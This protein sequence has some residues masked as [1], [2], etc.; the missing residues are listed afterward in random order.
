MSEPRTSSAKARGGR[1][2]QTTLRGCILCGG[3][4]TVDCVDNFG[5]PYKGCPNCKLVD[6]TKNNGHERE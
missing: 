3:Q 1:R 5:K 2:Y 6:F 4:C